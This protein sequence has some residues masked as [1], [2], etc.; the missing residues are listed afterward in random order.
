[1]TKRLFV[2]V[3]IFVVVLLLFFV[4]FVNKAD[5][6][7][8]YISSAPSSSLTVGQTSTL[9]AGQVITNFNVPA[10]FQ[11]TASCDWEFAGGPCVNVRTGPGVSYPKAVE[12]FSA[13]PGVPVSDHP[14]EVRSGQVFKVSQ[15]V[16]GT[17]GQ[18]WLKL[19]IPTSTLIYPNRIQGSWYVAA[20][21]FQPVVFSPIDSKADATKHIV[22]VLH[23]QTL[24]AEEGSNI[25]QTFKVSTGNP[26]LPTPT[27]NFSIMQKDPVGDHGRPI[28]R[29]AR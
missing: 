15:I 22:V 24:Y 27:G 25:V 29:T 11:V 20:Q 10:L 1:M 21:Y 26:D 18:E 17:D 16:E 8:L 3:I 7:G 28:A 23:T 2:F 6:A 5:G 14:Y 12:H 13:Y 9:T 19:Q 4:V